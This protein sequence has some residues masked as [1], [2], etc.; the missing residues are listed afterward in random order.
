MDIQSRASV[1]SQAPRK[2]FKPGI[3]LSQQNPD[4]QVFKDTTYL[5]ELKNENR[6]RNKVFKLGLWD[7]GKQERDTQDL[8]EGN[9]KPREKDEQQQEHNLKMIRMQTEHDFRMQMEHH[10]HMMD[11]AELRS[12]YYEQLEDQRQERLMEM[13]RKIANLRKKPVDEYEH[14]TENTE[15]YKSQSNVDEDKKGRS[16]ITQIPR[17]VGEAQQQRQMGEVLTSS[18]ENNGDPNGRL[19]GDANWNN[20]TEGETYVNPHHEM[21][22]DAFLLSDGGLGT[23][24][25]R[26]R[27]SQMLQLE[28]VSRRQRVRDL[29]HAVRD[30]ERP[31]EGGGRQRPERKPPDGE[32]DRGSGKRRTRSEK[33]E[34]RWDDGHKRGKERKLRRAAPTSASESESEDESKG[35]G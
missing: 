13:L 28:L 15:G 32:V 25:E 9:D 30:A 26:P 6:R 20:R 19:G 2:L 22:A 21:A 29:V 1:T 17:A 10:Q 16:N 24:K 3:D 12:A 5:D 7:Q 27:H 8:D 34:L 33:V 4:N 35:I 31:G 18:N 14:E 11:L 23:T